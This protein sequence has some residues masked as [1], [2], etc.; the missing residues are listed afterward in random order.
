MKIAVPT[1]DNMVDEHFGH[2][3]HFTILTV[4][5]AKVVGDETLPAP[6][7]CGCKSNVASVLADM[8]VK[9]LLAGNMGMGAVQV[10]GQNGIEVVRGCSGPV[11]DVADQYLAGNVKDQQI[12]CNHHD[13]GNH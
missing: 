8:G 13:C 12:A 4:E 1:R 7:G 3:Q 11:K 2:C 6:E 9:V 10:L 5:D